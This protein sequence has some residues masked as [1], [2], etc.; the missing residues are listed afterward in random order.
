MLKGITPRLY[1]ET[2]FSR[3]TTKNTLVVLPTGMGKTALAMMLAKHR[4]GLYPDSKILILAPTKPLAQQHL[5]TFKKHFDTDES[6]FALFT[7][8][9]NPIKRGELWKTAKIIFSTPQGL[10]NDSITERINLKDVSLL[11][12]DECLTEDSKIMLSTEDEKPIKD[13]YEN[14]IHGNKIFV[15]SFNAKNRN[16][17]NLRVVD[18]QKIPCIK[19]LYEIKTEHNKVM[20]ATQDH[21]FLIKNKDGFKW[22]R[23]EELS[24]QCK[25]AVYPFYRKDL[26][27]FSKELIDEE[28]IIKTYKKKHFK[29]LNNYKE[30]M[31]LAREHRFGSVKIHRKIGVGISQIN[32]WIYANHL[33]LPLRTIND[34]KEISLMPFT[35]NN[36]RSNII[37]RITGHLFGDGW[38][39]LDKKRMIYTM[40]F[41]GEI[42]NLKEIQEDLESLSIKYSNIHSRKTKSRINNKEVIGTTNSFLCADKRLIR[43]LLALGIVTGYKTKQKIE[44]P[45]WIANGPLEIKKEF[46]GALFGSEATTPAEKKKSA[47]FYSIRF[48]V[49]KIDSLKQNAYDYMDQIKKILNEFGVVVSQI[50]EREGNMWKDN[51]TKTI[52]LQ[53]TISN[54][55]YNMVR[56][57]ENIPF[58][59]SPKKFRKGLR[60]LYYLKD[61]AHTKS[62]RNKKQILALKLHKEGHSNH[63]IA[64]RINVPL[65]QIENWVY[66]KTAGTRM[67]PLSFRKFDSHNNVNQSVMLEK[68]ASIRKI[69]Q[70]EWVY[71]LTVEKNHNFIANGII[72]HNCHRSVGDYAYVFIANQYRKKAHYPRILALTASPGSDLEKISEVCKNL[73]IENIEV[74]TEDDPDVKQYMQKIKIDWINVDLPPAFAFIKKTIEQCYYSKLKEIKEL[75]YLNSILIR[76]IELLKLQAELHSKLNSGERN[77]EIMKSISLTAEATK[78]GHALELLETQGIYSLCMYLEK[79]IEESARTTVKAVKNL[80]NDERFRVIYETTKKLYENNIDH[81]KLKE[82]KKIVLDNKDKKMIIFSNY[83]DTA[84]KIKKELDSLKINSVV[85]VGQAK[86]R[87]T[88]L[89][90]KQ[91]KQILDDFRNDKFNIL[92]ATSVA[93]EGLD[94]PSVDLVIFYEPVPSAVRTIQRR[95]RTGRN[96][97]GRV[98]ILVANNT[99]D[100][101]YQWSNHH[102][103]KKMHRILNDLNKKIALNGLKQEPVEQ[104]A[105]K[106]V[107]IIC[108]DRE[109]ANGVVKQLV[110]LGIKVDLKRLYI[111]DY[112]LS[113]RC[114]VEL[115]KIPDFVDSIIDGRLLEQL[116]C[117][118]KADKPILILEGIED[119]Y[120]QRNI[121]PNAIRGMLSTIAV[122]YGIPIIQTKNQKETIEL[123]HIIAKREQD[124]DKKQFSMHTSKKPITD[125]EMQ[126]YIVSSLPSV[127]P[128]LA[129]E[130]LHNFRTVKGIFNAKEDDLKQVPGLGDKT[131]KEIQKVLDKDYYLNNTS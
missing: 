83:R 55:D 34:M 71:D 8:E 79:L 10:E 24:L 105:T 18:A 39:T 50:K 54:E 12:F 80:V 20:K 56:F 111:G 130:L 90:Q 7:G 41:S 11:V 97:S 93:E 19:E 61:K 6:N 44:V 72:V 3:S 117:L 78:I 48:S 60:I 43:L 119:I 64:N 84:S 120:S 112:Q 76:K 37:A 36:P 32:N 108:D 30:A 57:Y 25:L 21:K 52:K 16:F 86:K 127:G 113:E 82:L 109:K 17:E 77:M 23:A 131:A 35:Y 27:K 106:Q 100:V 123:L 116:R 88:G 94:V 46:L 68:V 9:I 65:F 107:K 91:Q 125:K 51:K 122:G 99:R 128:S 15:K 66:G 103:E 2:I 110:E 26:K 101:G 98:I 22:V 5:E 104:T 53:L 42:D 49:N 114:I 96:D 87:E 129:K 70:V 85:F 73:D 29:N 81:P 13:V 126:E 28:N 74:R 31:K 4:L 102:K 115:K 33:P 38:V 121:H 118:S 14:F 40:G 62:F 45:K 69:E 124:P 63:I 92:I 89:N 95:G 47:N 75:G 67:I 1:Q 59:Y 58:R